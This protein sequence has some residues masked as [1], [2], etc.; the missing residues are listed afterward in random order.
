MR[1]LQDL[2][3]HYYAGEDS[4]K[5][6]RRSRSQIYPR[7]RR[8]SGTF[9]A[10]PRS[11]ERHSSDQLEALNARHP[12]QAQS[13]RLSLDSG[14]ERSER[15]NSAMRGRARTRANSAMCTSSLAVD[16]GSLTPSAQSETSGSLYVRV[17]RDARVFGK[18]TRIADEEYLEPL[19][20]IGRKGWVEGG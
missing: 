1:A 19:G 3:R 4:I 5:G 7:R 14:N 2:K 16:S 8:R 11:G 15:R 9:E 13:A 12:R 6:S 10:K 20:R 17:P 18:H